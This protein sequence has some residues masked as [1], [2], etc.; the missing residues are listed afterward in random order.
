MTERDKPDA[1]PRDLRTDWHRYVDSL[2]PLRPVL[3]AYC[4]RL[5]ARSGTPRISCRTP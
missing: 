2:V 4:R 1:L 5:S 3:F